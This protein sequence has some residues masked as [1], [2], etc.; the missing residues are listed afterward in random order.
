MSKA[1]ERRVVKSQCEQAQYD[2]QWRNAYSQYGCGLHLHHVASF[3]NES[4]RPALV[5]N[6][7]EEVTSATG[8]VPMVQIRGH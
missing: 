2:C 5:K 7:K 4:L 6:F 1:G 8:W 3:P